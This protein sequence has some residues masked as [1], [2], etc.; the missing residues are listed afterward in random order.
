M[1]L[2]I[3][4]V[5]AVSFQDESQKD[6]WRKMV[7]YVLGYVTTFSKLT[8]LCLIV[9]PLSF[10][11][12]IDSIEVIVPGQCLYHVSYRCS[13]YAAKFQNPPKIWFTTIIRRISTA[14]WILQIL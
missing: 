4:D 7:Y 13:K 12:V 1:N 14:I 11:G 5:L 2:K 6:S 3:E 8:L 9:L 10:K